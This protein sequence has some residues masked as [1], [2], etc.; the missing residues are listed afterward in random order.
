MKSLLVFSTVTFLASCTAVRPPCAPVI[1]E[2]GLYIELAKQPYFSQGVPPPGKN[3]KIERF[4][5]GYKIDVGE[6][7]HDDVIYV[8][9]NGHILEVVQHP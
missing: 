5:C 6:S 2:F 1:G 8:D 9:A 3:L 7:F 4:G